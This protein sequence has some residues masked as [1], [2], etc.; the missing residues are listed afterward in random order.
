M[1]QSYWERRDSN[2]KA[3]KIKLARKVAKTVMNNTLRLG[4]LA[5]EKDLY[6]SLNDTKVHKGF[7][8][9]LSLCAIYGKMIS[10]C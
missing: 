6:R 3:D 1:P 8:V 10:N 9:K 2:L 5:W 4:G 7:S